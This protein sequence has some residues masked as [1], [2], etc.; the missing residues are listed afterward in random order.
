MP[1]REVASPRPAPF[2]SVILSFFNEATVLSELV[3][4]LRNTLENEVADGHI[5]R[6]EL[7]FVNDAST[8][9]SELILK[10]EADRNGDI[11]LLTMSHNF[12]VSPCVI[13]GMEHS[14]G[15]VI[16]YM[17][18][19]LQDPPEVIPTMLAA[20]RAAGDADVV[21]TIRKTRK[22][23]SRIKLLLTRLGYKILKTI[24]DIDII[25]NSGD[26][27][28]LS[29]RVVEQIVAM[30][31]RLPFVRGMV[32]WVGYKQI[33]VPY[34]R[35]PR[36]GGKTKF[37]MLGSRM[38]RNFLFSALISFSSAPLL[39][40]VMF[41]LIASMISFVFLIYIIIQWLLLTDVTQGW[42]TLMAMLTFLGSL[43]LLT[44]GI[45]GLYMNTI[46]Y[47]TKRRPLYIVKSIYGMDAHEM[48]AKQSLF[49]AGQKP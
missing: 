23:E 47:E 5:S 14:R 13:A 7:V 46:F 37:P 22:G 45:N 33:A 11:V 8:D 39:F 29:R 20:W 49:A 41:G 43:Q 25:E 31:E 16:V 18:A 19:D 26:F 27:K 48:P 36:R 32:Y 24:S 6:Y 1:A 3:S 44:N 10:E 34:D 28:L 35:E 40:T 15:D 21:N 42:T 38:L 9:D 12:G 2:L 4:R 17:D 30:N